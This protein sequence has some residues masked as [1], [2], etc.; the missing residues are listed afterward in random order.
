[1]GK[2]VVIFGVGD[3]AR[4]AYVYLTKDS[5]YEVAAFTVNE[6][7]LP[8]SRN[9][10]DLPVVP[11]ET[12]EKT[13]PVDQYEML[14]A[15]GY[16]RVNQAREEVYLQCKAKGYRMITYVHSKSVLTGFNEIGENTF[17]FENNVIQP[18]VKIGN[19]VVI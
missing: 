17:I 3:F 10:F 14:A 2:K 19:N 13:H 8:E 1:M 11:F 15:V 12:L 6:R 5:P 16:K 7:Y 18:F 9:L 4:M